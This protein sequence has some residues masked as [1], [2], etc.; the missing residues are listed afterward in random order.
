[1][2]S[3]GTVYAGLGENCFEDESEW[4]QIME[5]HAPLRDQDRQEMAHEARDKEL[6]KATVEGSA[7]VVG[8][9]A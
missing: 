4:Q 6:A 1:L 9:G 7:F 3:P 5:D 8:D 2:L